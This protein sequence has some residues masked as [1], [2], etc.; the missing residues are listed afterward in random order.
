MQAL[1]ICASHPSPSRLL[2][3]VAAGTL[4]LAAPATAQEF[5]SKGIPPA[6][7]VLQWAQE[8]APRNEFYID[9]DRDVEV[10]RFKTP[11]DL[12][13]CAAGGRGWSSRDRHGFPIKVNWDNQSAIIAPGNCLAFDAMRVSVRSALPLPQD[14][15]LKGT[16][17]IVK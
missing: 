9:N 12:E 7:P 6:D 8:L 11:H 5:T 15:V 2:A 1:R 3:A 16:F 10:I 13:L 17:R 4:L 14:I